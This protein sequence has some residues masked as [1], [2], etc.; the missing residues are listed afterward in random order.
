M[1]S[2]RISLGL[3][4]FLILLNLGTTSCEKDPPPSPQDTTKKDS[5][6][7]DSATRAY[8]EKIFEAMVLNQ[9]V[10]II[11]AVDSSGNNIT[12]NYQDMVIYLRKETYYNGPLEILAKGTKHMGTWKS[13]SDYSRLDLSITGLPEFAFFD[14]TWRFTYK[15][16]TLLKIAPVLNPGKKTLHLEKIP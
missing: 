14:K 5:T 12:P 1:K 7:N 2:I 9:P 13:N 3:I 4:V 15:S 6:F 10:R 8:M 11:L 16:Q